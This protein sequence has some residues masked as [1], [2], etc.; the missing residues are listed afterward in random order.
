VQKGSCINSTKLSKLFSDP[1]ISSPA[2]ATRKECACSKSIDIGSYDTCPHGCLYCYANTDKEK[3]K[4]ALKNMDMS[5]NG[6][7]FHV[8]ESI[9]TKENIQTSL[10]V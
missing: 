10:F 7:G 6:L 4:A 1:S 8:D 5:W 2:A 3:S 9:K